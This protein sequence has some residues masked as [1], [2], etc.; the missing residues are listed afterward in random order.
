MLLVLPD[1][2]YVLR[3]MRPFD[4]DV[5]NYLAER[6]D[7]QTGIVGRSRKVSYG[8]MALDLSERDVARRV[9]ST[10]WKVTSDQVRNAV[11][12]L[13]DEGLLVSLSKK[14]DKC[15]LILRRVFLADLLFRDNSVQNP[16]AA[17]L[18]EQL[19]YL[20]GLFPLNNN[21][22][23]EIKESSEQGRIDSVAITSFSNINNNADDRFLMSLD[24]QY[25]EPELLM[26][27]HRGGGY[28]MAGVNPAWISGFIAYWWGEGK[29]L[30][31]QREWTAKL[32]MKLIGY[33]RQPGMFETLHGISEKSDKNSTVNGEHLPDWA[34]PPRDDGQLVSWMR[35]HQYGDPPPGLDYKQARAY[36][37]RAITI[38]LAQWRKGLS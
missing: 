1:E 33:L 34:R 27:L 29:R 22:I 26:I 20:L 11:R 24:W 3:E 25:S 36:L 32:G 30:G 15:D 6:V 10:L 9:K 21:K 18:P 16:V 2:L 17:Q 37:H 4:R 31:N 8:G 19:T 5:F 13:I 28:T 12:R 23:E 14:G 35:R 38:R 7:Y